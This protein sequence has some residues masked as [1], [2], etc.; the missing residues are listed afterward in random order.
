MIQYTT[1]ELLKIKEFLTE[2]KDL[3][4]KEAYDVLMEDIRRKNMEADRD[5][6]KHCGEKE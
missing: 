6:Y 2:N 5:F 3:L 1:S 4:E